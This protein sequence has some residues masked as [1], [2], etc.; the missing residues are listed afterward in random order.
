VVTF[1]YGQY[2][3][4]TLPM[5]EKTYPI[6]LAAV[7]PHYVGSVV[8]T[9]GYVYANAAAATAAGK[10]AVAMIAYVSSTGHGLALALADEDAQTLNQA[11]SVTEETAV[12]GGTWRLPTV[13]DWRH[14]FI[15]CG[16]GAAEDDTSATVYFASLQSKLTAAGGSTLKKSTY[17]ADDDYTVAIGDETAIF[18]IESLTDYLQYPVRAFLAF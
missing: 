16:N 6:A 14:V 11:Q 1:D 3:E 4:V 2:Y 18:A 17:W 15:A 13:S 7:T 9:D 10:T 12:T 5:K 8:T